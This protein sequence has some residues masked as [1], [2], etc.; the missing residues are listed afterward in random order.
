MAPS[1]YI[2][3]EKSM[4]EYTKLNSAAIDR[5]V[6]GGWEWG[7]PISHE[8]FVRAQK[9]DW[10]V[11]L[12]PT[13]PVPKDWFPPLRGCKLLGLASGGGQQM[14]IFAALEAQCTVLDYSQKQ[15][16]SERVFSE[17]EG[18]SIKIVHAD[19]TKPLP[20]GDGSFDLIF[21][22]ISNCYVQEVFPIWQECFRVLRPGGTLLAGVDNGLNFIFDDEQTTLTYPLPYNPLKNAALY[23]QCLKTG[24]AVQF[25]HTTEE[26]LRG[27]LKAGFQLQ[28]LYEDTNGTGK[29]HEYGVPTFLAFK[30]QKP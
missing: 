15:L 6:E 20:F 13:K 24:D 26:Q 7:Q 5:W 12:S 2:Q 21:H 4:I 3:R 25:S 30:A 10:S 8:A 14:P 27:L 16:E 17:Q 11:L 29:L 28:D 19:M 23:E 9:G 1:K 18:Y 22:P